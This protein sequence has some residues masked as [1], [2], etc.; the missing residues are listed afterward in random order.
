MATVFNLAHVWAHV[1]G[2][3][4]FSTHLPGK[5]GCHHLR[6][7]LLIFLPFARAQSPARY[8]HLSSFACRC[9][10]GPLHADTRGVWRGEPLPAASQGSRKR[11]SGSLN[12]PPGFMAQSFAVPG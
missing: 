7:T 1:E 9:V 8:C 11:A 3:L 2:V 6:Q 10:V 12:R 4:S 5:P